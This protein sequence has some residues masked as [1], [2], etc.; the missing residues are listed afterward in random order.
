MASPE[1]PPQ[2]LL[3]PGDAAHVGAHAMLGGDDVTVVAGPS[4]TYAGAYDGAYAAAREY[5]AAALAPSPA[6][7]VMTAVAAMPDGLEED[8]HFG[9]EAAAPDDEEDADADLDGECGRGGAYALPHSAAAFD[10]QIDF[11]VAAAAADA[12]AAASPMAAPPVALE[13][14]SGGVPRRSACDIRTARL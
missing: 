2:P 9:G 1:R 7:A 13:P 12:A 8:M 3:V 4:P 5:A 10:A 6:G 14:P 11:A